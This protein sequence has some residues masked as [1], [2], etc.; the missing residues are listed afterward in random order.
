M[1]ASDPAA[2][3][4]A[5]ANAVARRL[6]VA[7]PDRDERTQQVAMEML[8]TISQNQGVDFSSQKPRTPRRANV[9]LRSLALGHNFLAGKPQLE[10]LGARLAAGEDFSGSENLG[11]V[12]QSLRALV[13]SDTLRG[14]AATHLMLPV[15][16]SLL[17]YDVRS[18]T[19]S[20]A[21]PITKRRVS[22]PLPYRPQRVLMRGTGITLARLLLHPPDYLGP[23]ADDA[24]R[25]CGAITKALSADSPFAKLGTALKD[26]EDADRAIMGDEELAS[27]DAAADP[28]LKGLGERLIRHAVAV[29]EDDAHPAQVRLLNLR[30]VLALDLAWHL[31]Q[32][33]WTAAGVPESQR[34]LLLC[35]SPKERAV[36][37][38]RVLSEESYQLNHQFMTRAV[39][40]TIRETMEKR[41]SSG[42]GWADFFLERK[43][44]KPTP[45]SRYF[46]ELRS[47]MAADPN[48][49]FSVYAHKTFEAPGDGYVRPVDAF[50]VLLESCGLLLGTGRW[51][52]FRP[53][54]GL[55]T[56]L[57]SARPGRAVMD[58]DEFLRWLRSEWSI[59]IGEY[60]AAGTRLVDRA[61][62]SALQHNREY[63]ERD[64]V[65]NGL[66]TALSDQTVMVGMR[67]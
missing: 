54:P 61:E 6:F 63:F 17:W 36:N 3:P 4:S 26:P 2:P 33:S 55:L 19:S 41:S 8:L 13:D 65:H 10:A 11:L 59:V 16:D 52:Y 57:V 47:A 5:T 27:W 43:P 14:G 29:M 1:A 31:A 7:A 38:V 40:A 39:I 35:H 24:R 25:A 49:D 9:L 44:L 12:Q 46:E 58:A 23:V 50:R 67:V 30:R 15:H 32:A 28:K 64:L 22:R 42:A 21:D 66:A 62:G 20:T 48:P 53:S 45:S 18:R 34:Y 51:R 60:E 56:A 37:R